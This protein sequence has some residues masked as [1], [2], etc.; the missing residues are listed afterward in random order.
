MKVTGMTH[1]VA[2]KEHKMKSLQL[3]K[4][5]L[6]TILRT[7][8]GS[9]RQVIVTDGRVREAAIA[10]RYLRAGVLPRVLFVQ[11]PEGVKE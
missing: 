7:P 4:Y 5:D 2:V 6:Y 8:I 3:A 1:T 10:W 11:I 9:G